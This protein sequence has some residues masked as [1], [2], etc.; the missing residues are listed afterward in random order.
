MPFRRLLVVD[1]ILV[2]DGGPEDLFL[3][4]VTHLYLL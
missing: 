4:S 2:L 3:A 1:L